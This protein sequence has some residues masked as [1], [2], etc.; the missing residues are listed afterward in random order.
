MLS[1]A[2]I[3]LPQ[4]ASIHQ[5]SLLRKARKPTDTIHSNINRYLDTESLD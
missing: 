3:E 4:N 5:V 1:S 2:N